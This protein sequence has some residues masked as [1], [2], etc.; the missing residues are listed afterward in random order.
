MPLLPT[1]HADNT[2]EIIHAATINDI[3]DAINK[4]GPSFSL[5][6]Y[7]TGDGVANDSAGVSAALAAAGSTGLVTSPP[8]KT[9][10]LDSNVT[11]AT[12]GARLEMNGSTFKKKSTLTT[13]ALTVTGNNV[14]IRN[15]RRRRQQGGGA[16]GEGIRWSGTGGTLENST[17]SNCR[18]HGIYVSGALTCRNVTSSGHGSAFGDASGFF[19][20]RCRVGQPRRPLCGRV[21]HAGGGAHQHERDRVRGQRDVLPERRGR[22]VD[23]RRQRGLVGLHLRLRQ[24]LPERHADQGVAGIAITDWKFGTI[25]GS[26]RARRRDHVG[27]ERRVQGLL[28]VPGWDDPQPWRWW[29]RVGVRVGGRDRRHGCRHVGLFVRHRDL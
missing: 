9:Y 27:G 20:T 17:V 29:L 19:A 23:L 2:N 13:E 11:F 12:A 4:T 28:E 25:I 15:A 8:G 22:G 14:T 26:T 5:L 10:L 18:V 6:N 16:T 1:T 3:A 7:A 24:R 21:E